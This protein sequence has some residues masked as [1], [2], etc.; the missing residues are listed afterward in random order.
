MPRIKELDDVLKLVDELPRERQLKCV[1]TL[2]LYVQDWEDRVST[3]LS[4]RE[5]HRERVRRF[6]QKH[7]IDMAKI[8]REIDGDP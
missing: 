5:Y 8:L 3:G 6:A 1:H 4:D 7:G 2:S